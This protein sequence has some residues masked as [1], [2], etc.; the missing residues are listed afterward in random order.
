MPWLTAAD[1]GIAGERVP[2]AMHQFHR[3]QLHA[4]A[5]GSASHQTTFATAGA[6]SATH[7][8]IAL[9]DLC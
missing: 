1:L 4:R 8:T 6:A 7:A 2:K 9:A 5:A 3:T